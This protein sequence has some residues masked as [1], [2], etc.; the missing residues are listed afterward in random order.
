MNLLWIPHSPSEPGAHRRDQY[1]I[2]ILRERHRIYT[3]TW[4][5]WKSGDRFK[6]VMA[7][8]RFYP[9]T[10]DGLDAFHVRRIPD[11]LRPFRKHYKNVGINQHFFHQDIRRI[12]RECN[13]DMVIAGPTSFMTGYPPFDLDVPLVFDYLDCADWEAKPDHPEKVYMQESDAIL[14][15]SSIAKERAEQFGKPSLYLPNGADIERMRS[16][17]G[18]AVRKKYGL[19]DANVVSLIGLTC[20]PRHYFLESV[21]HAKKQMP[22]LKCLLVGHSPAI[23]ASLAKIPN[24]E[25]T[26]I[27]TGPVPYAEI[28]S[29]F[30]ASD[31]GMYPVDEAVY[32]SA[33]SPIKI[34]EYTAAGKPVV[35]PRITEAERLGFSNLVFAAPEAEPYGEG[36]LRAFNQP[37]VHVPQIDN[38]DWTYLADQLDQFLHE[39]VNEPA[40]ER[41]APAIQ[42]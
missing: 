31:V 13:I 5:T 18:D 34:F 14:C 40:H 28:A 24:A 11:F 36:I 1:F 30:A 4:Q 16:A 25:E 21:L 9:L 29:Y 41:V 26:F 33:A 38:F 7:G 39:L 37:P 12:V 2:R 32:Y 42:V 20:S 3:L 15:V 23:E 19:E 22:N 6:A 10:I 35:V 8:L 27:F 17:K